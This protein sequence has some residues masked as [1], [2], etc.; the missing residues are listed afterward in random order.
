MEDW[1][2]QAK[3]NT[4]NFMIKF[5]TLAIK[6]NTDELYAIFLLKKNVRAD[7]IKTTLGYPPIIAPKTLKEWK[8]AIT[9]VE[10]GYEST[11]RWQDYK[12]ESGTTYKE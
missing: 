12:T 8:V 1:D 2:L 11:E 5:K 6:A 10:Q 3:K 7:I 9:L 4:A